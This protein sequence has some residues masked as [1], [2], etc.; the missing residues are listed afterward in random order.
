MV[1]TAQKARRK[2]I[3]QSCEFLCLDINMVTLLEVFNQLVQHPFCNFP[4]Q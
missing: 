1:S 4:E 3:L 2:L